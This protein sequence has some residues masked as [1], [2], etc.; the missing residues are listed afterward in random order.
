MAI[1]KMIREAQL[2]SNYYKKVKTDKKVTVIKVKTNRARK[3][4]ILV[5]IQINNK[6]YKQEIE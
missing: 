2:M 1:T 3:D 4:K 6:K 5:D